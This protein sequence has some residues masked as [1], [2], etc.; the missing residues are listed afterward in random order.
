MDRRQ[1]EEDSIQRGHRTLRL[2][3]G[4]GQDAGNGLSCS[5]EGR[6]KPRLASRVARSAYRGT[7]VSAHTPTSI[8]PHQGGGGA[9][10]RVRAAEGGRL[11]ASSC[12][13]VASPPEESSGRLRDG[14]INRCYEMVNGAGAASLGTLS[15]SS[16]K[17]AVITSLT[18]TV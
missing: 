2:T 1:G 17:V 4:R 3:S 7:W 5:V 18:V 13:L 10:G 8:L 11:S 16:V 14:C 6:L 12:L 9:S 15:M